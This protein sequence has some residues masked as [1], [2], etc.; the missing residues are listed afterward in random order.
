MK[1]LDLFSDQAELYAAA[2]PRYP[3]ELFRFIADIAPAHERCWDCGAGSGQASVGL[4]RFFRMVEA[5]DASAEQIAN[6]QP[7]EGVR[8]SVQPAEHSGFTEG[9]MDAVCVAAALH[10]F[11]LDRFYAEVARVLKPGGVLVAWGYDWFKVSPEFDAQ[12]Q[13][14]VLDVIQPYWAPQLAALWKGYRDIAFPFP[15]IATPA[16][17]MTLQWNLPQLMTYVHTWSATR[18]C[19]EQQGR[20]FLDDAAEALRLNWG[21]PQRVREVSM[22]LHMIAGRK[23][24]PV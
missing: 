13:S 23:P 6:A 18:R 12:F 16:L 24:V 7:M 11:D 15:R 4:A 10:W 2:R 1:F 3:D 19:I 14:A 9:S 5:T 20:D 17:S 8:Y 21:P 22:R